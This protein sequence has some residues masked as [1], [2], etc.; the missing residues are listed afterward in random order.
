MIHPFPNQPQISN[1]SID[2]SE[3]ECRA[4]NLSRLASW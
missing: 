2:I 4:I 3:K 1:F